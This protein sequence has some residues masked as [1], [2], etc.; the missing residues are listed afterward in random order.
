MNSD[1]YKSSTYVD[2]NIY[3]MPI[4][5]EPCST[6]SFERDVTEL[7]NSEND[8]FTLHQGGILFMQITL[9]VLHTR[10]PSILLTAYFKS[11]YFRCQL[12]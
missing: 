10:D 7:E 12:T 1:C 8:F 3:R 9:M 4:A 6:E 11:C 5:I 2:R